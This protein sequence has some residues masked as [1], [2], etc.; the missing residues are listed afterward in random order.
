MIRVLGVERLLYL[1]HGKQS[2]GGK[3]FRK[4]IAPWTYRQVLNRIESK[5]QENRV[6]LVWLEPANTSR[7]YPDDGT[8]QKEKRRGEKFQCLACGRTGDADTVGAQNL[9]ARTLATLGSVESPRL[10]KAMSE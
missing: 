2:N 9:L 6:L 7:T 5:S 3:S 1:K 8:V 10:K 4:A